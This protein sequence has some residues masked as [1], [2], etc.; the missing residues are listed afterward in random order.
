MHRGFSGDV[1][2]KA[3]IKSAADKRIAF[4]KNAEPGIRQLIAQGCHNLQRCQPLGLHLPGPLQQRALKRGCL[5]GTLRKGAGRQCIAGQALSPGKCLTG[6]RGKRRGQGLGL[7][8]GRNRQKR[9][10]AKAL[11]KTV[12]RRGFTHLGW[13]RSRLQAVDNDSVPQPAA[14]RKHRARGQ[15]HWPW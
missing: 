3:K 4:I 9:A 6:G 2:A 8:L 7:G 11:H 12:D 10:G 13:P 5:H 15:A 14:Q 1:G